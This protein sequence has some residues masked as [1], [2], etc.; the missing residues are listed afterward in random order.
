MY[1]TAKDCPLPPTRSTFDCTVAVQQHNEKNTSIYDDKN[2][3]VKS[4]GEL[5]VICDDKSFAF[6]PS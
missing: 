5:D 1:R 2:N 3:R 4:K 6:D